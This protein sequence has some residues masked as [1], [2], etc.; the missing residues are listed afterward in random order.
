TTPE[1]ITERIPDVIQR[2]IYQ[3]TDHDGKMDSATILHG[4]VLKYL[5][6]KSGGEAKWSRHARWI[7]VGDSLIKFIKNSM[8]YGLFPDDYHFRNISLI[9]EKF[10]NDTQAKKDVVLWS[11]ADVLL[12]DALLQIIRDV[13]LGRLQKDSITLRSD[14]TLPKEF[15]G[16]QVEKI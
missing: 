5:Y 10:A 16:Q 8:L 2:I 11:K 3:I 7:P 9:N 6:D 15:Y 14:S 1:Q 13:K 4:D 12:T